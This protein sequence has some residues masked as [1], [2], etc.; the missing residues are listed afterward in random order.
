MVLSALEERAAEL[1][2]KNTRG[3]I[4]KKNLT[5]IDLKIA[6]RDSEPKITIYT[7]LH[8]N[9]RGRVFWPGR[10]ALERLS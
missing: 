9:L 2:C 10:F 5:Q 3:N 1:L 4:L 7:K 8:G 6:Q